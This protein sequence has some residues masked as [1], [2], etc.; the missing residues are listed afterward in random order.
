MQLKTLQLKEICDLAIC[1][2]KK[3]SRF[4]SAYDIEKLDVQIKD[5]NSCDK[6]QGGTSIASQ[7]VTEVDIKSQE[8]ILN[9]ISSVTKKYDL[10]LLTEEI[11]DDNSRF[12]K[13]YFWC[14]DPLDGTLPYT[15]GKEGYSVSI[16]LVAKDGTSIIGVVCNPITNDLY[17]C[18]KGDGVYKNGKKWLQAQPLKNAAFTFINDRSFYKHKDYKSIT[19]SLY[20]KTSKMG[21]SAFKMVKQGGAVM[22]AIWV[23]ENQPACYFKLPKETK[24]GGSIWDFAATSCIFNELGLTA[25]SFSGDPLPLNSTSSTFMNK[26]GVFYSAGI[27]LK[28][29]RQITEEAQLATTKN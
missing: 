27:Q 17:H 26:H 10:G 21:H 13:N 22:N 28:E 25:S 12:E 4:I 20:F 18:I 1:A 9:E 11:N 5:S 8:I 15:Q 6:P 14:I 23:L 2:A 24:G 16:A 29:V 19:T 3:A 7:V